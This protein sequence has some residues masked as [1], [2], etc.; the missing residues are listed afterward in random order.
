V[1]H[2][3]IAALRRLTR[4]LIVTRRPFL[5]VCLGHQVL[6]G[7]LG[8]ALRR[9]EPPA[10]GVAREIDFFGQRRRVGF[11][12]T[13]AAHSQTDAVAC[14]LTG[15]SVEVSREAS[16]GEVH[17]LRKP[18]LRSVQF[19]LESVLTERGLTILRD[20]LTPL[21]PAQRLPAQPSAGGRTRRV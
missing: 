20:L 13:F 5:S 1:A 19:H 3:T 18:G 11:Y 21:L 16:T 4:A 15:E 6:A 14:G 12:N 10:Q 8:L 17:G 7:L 2:P 9:K